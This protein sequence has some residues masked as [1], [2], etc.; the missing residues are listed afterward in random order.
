VESVI[1]ER[2]N[3]GKT[4]GMMA[5]EADKWDEFRTEIAELRKE[6]FR[7]G[8]GGCRGYGGMMGGHHMWGYD[9]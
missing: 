5:V 7:Q 8:R 4:F 3:T 2:N 9:Y 6:N 1:D